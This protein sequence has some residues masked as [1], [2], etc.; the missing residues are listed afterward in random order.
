MNQTDNIAVDVQGDRALVTFRLPSSGA[1][2]SQVVLTWERRAGLWRIVQEAITPAPGAS[3]R[4]A[5]SET[6][7]K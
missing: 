3:K 7:Q 4:V 2:G 6:P 5:L 1:A